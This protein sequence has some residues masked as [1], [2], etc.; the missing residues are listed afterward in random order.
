MR[1][2]TFH[3]F[4]YTLFFG[5]TFIYFAIDGTWQCQCLL[6]TWIPSLVSEVCVKVSCSFFS[7]GKGFFIYS[8]YYSFM[9]CVE[10]SFPSLWLVFSQ[11]WYIN[12]LI[13]I[14]SNIS[15]F[16]LWSACFIFHLKNFLLSLGREYGWY[17]LLKCFIVLPLTLRFHPAWNYLWPVIWGNTFVSLHGYFVVP[18]LFVEM[19]FL[20]L[21]L[22]SASPVRY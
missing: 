13:L 8:G 16:P 14:C 21:L 7:I 12:I 10:K 1:L 9:S 2:N 3:I 19:T 5:K 18:V 15:I 6:A 4:I 22:W 17:F 11:C 20:S